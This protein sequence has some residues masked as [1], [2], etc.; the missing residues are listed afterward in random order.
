MV[1]GYIIT[2]VCSKGGSPNSKKNPTTNHWL[3]VY[4]IICPFMS[5]I[6]SW[7]HV[8][9]K[10][11][12]IGKN[13]SPYRP[14]DLLFL[15]NDWLEVHGIGT[16]HALLY[17]AWA[18]C[19]ESLGKPRWSQVFSWQIDRKFFPGPAR[20]SNRIYVRCLIFSLRNFC[21]TSYQDIYIWQF[22]TYKKTCEVLPVCRL[23]FVSSWG[24]L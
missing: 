16:Q 9:L 4:C 2:K 11:T 8:F 6:I 22:K 3:T 7:K 21:V 1:S 18:H 5:G 10:M 12:D 23:L 20:K 15:T 19:L 24:N 14:T 13:R 17:E